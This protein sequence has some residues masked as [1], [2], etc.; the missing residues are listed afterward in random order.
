MSV[1]QNMQVGIYDYNNEVVE[2]SLWQLLQWKHALKLEIRTQGMAGGPMTFK[3][4]KRISTH[5]RK[6]LNAPRK[7]TV[8]IMYQHITE[9]LDSINEQLGV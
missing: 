3:G 7:Y 4:G 9:S 2:I 5:V 6:F 8:Q 1:M